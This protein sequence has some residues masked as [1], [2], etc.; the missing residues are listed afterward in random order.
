MS[1]TFAV[2]DPNG[3]TTCSDCFAVVREDD[4]Q[5]HRGWHDDLIRN[6]AGSVSARAQAST[7]RRGGTGRFSEQRSRARLSIARQPGRR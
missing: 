7:G 3:A 1:E 5:Q 6:L 2:R 4:W